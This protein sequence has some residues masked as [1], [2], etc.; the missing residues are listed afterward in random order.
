MF[1]EEYEKMS[2]GDRGLFSETVNDLL[3]QCYIVR[4]TY[5]R[6]SKMFR[7]N[8]GYLFIE[9]YYSVF[10]EYL[11]YMDMTLSKNDEDGVIFVTSSAERNHFRMDPTT[12]LIVFALRSF[13][14][15][16]LEKAPNEPEPLMTS[17]QLMTLVQDLGLSNASKRLSFASIASIL[18][19]LDSFNVVSRAM[20]S[21][22]DPSFS[23]FVLPTIRYVLSSEKLNSLYSYLTNPEEDKSEPS[24]FDYP[25]ENGGNN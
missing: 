7:A 12:T 9:R 3:Y 2:R 25:Q 6:K 18:R 1:Q 14:E 10:E 15:G 5:D 22:G 13:Y 16:Q 21:Y 24:L 8:P 4:K 11:S 19:T 20:N 23:F 17:G